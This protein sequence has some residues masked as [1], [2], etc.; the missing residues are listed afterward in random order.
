MHNFEINSI[1]D[2]VAN[3]SFQ[4]WILSNDEKEGAYWS[5]WIADNP[6]KLEWVAAARSVIQVL[7]AN[8][9]ALPPDEVAAAAAAIQN[10]ILQEESQHVPGFDLHS[11]RRSRINSLPVRFKWGIAASLLLAIFAG[12]LIVQTAKV[13][14]ARAYE[15][16]LDKA[17]KAGTTYRNNS[18]GARRIYLPDGS[19]VDLQTGS[20][21]IYMVEDAVAR[22]EIFL[23]GEAFFSVATDPSHPFIVY[24]SNIVTRVLGTSFRI[25]AVPGE[26]VASITVC[27]GKVSV[28]KTASFTSQDAAEGFVLTPNQKAEYD[29]KKEQISKALVESP[30]VTKKDPGDFSFEGAPVIQIFRELQDAYGISIVFDEQTLS[31]C[32]VTAVLDDK[33]FYGK[34]NTVCKIINA[35]YEIID[36]TI[37]I[38]AKGCKS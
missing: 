5:R 7:A 18:P 28:Y 35:T 11:G 38:S 32:S 9:V 26:T 36:G 1:D 33:N 17:T 31:T 2:L 14:N 3:A 8:T 16:I 27:T 21:L 22:R 30:Q 15:S 29:I 20:S 23:T 19:E 34:L 10:K 4:Q 6:E 13:K 24:T 12:T 25:K 37:V